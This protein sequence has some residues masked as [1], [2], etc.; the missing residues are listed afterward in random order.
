MVV[1]RLKR[2]HKQARWSRCG[3]RMGSLGEK[4]L[5]R[6]LYEFKDG[7]GMEIVRV[8]GRVAQSVTTVCGQA[9][10]GLACGRSL[11]RPC[12][13]RPTGFV[14]RQGD[15]CLHAASGSKAEAGRTLPIVAGRARVRGD[16]GRAEG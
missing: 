8:E 11:I 5:V 1:E 16:T 13:G 6:L 12:V 2:C 7:G 9:G 4:L 10:F 14:H 15:Q 3:E